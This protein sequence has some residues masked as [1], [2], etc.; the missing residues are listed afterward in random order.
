MWDNGRASAPDMVQRCFTLWD[1]LNPDISLHIVE[2][3]EM[4]DRLSD[5]GLD[6]YAHNATVN[7]DLL[8][9]DLLTRHGGC[10]IDA[11]LV[12]FGPLDEWL[13]GKLDQ[14]GFFGFARPGPDRPISSWFLV[15]EPDHIL[16]RTWKE[17]YIELFRHQRTPL[18][19]HRSITAFSA[20]QRV[21]K[22]RF[23]FVRPGPGRKAKYYP[24]FMMHYQF[25]Y[26]L[27]NDADFATAWEKVP[28]VSALPSLVAGH[29]CRAS[30]TEGEFDAQLDSLLGVSP[31]YKLDR[32][33][34]ACIRVV[35]KAEELARSK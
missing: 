17:Q 5:L 24:Y 29:A 2:R 21:K 10:W 7:S 22:D 8:R 1:D 6:P 9:L 12:P 28:K 3:A 16:I 20:A 32:R 33:Q 14:S 30:R 35:E 25:D 11:T 31:I 34:P 27:K 18:P 26:L 13:T 23:W 4:E 19:P 15:S